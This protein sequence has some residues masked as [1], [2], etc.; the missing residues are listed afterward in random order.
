MVGLGLSI[1]PVLHNIKPVF[2]PHCLPNAFVVIKCVPILA[3]N[4]NG[5]DGNP[6][7]RTGVLWHV[8]YQET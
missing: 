6:T 7:A 1:R 8:G 4:L 2:C 5:E 3:G